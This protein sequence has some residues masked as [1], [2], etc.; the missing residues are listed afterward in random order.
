MKRSLRR[1]N[2][3][4][5]A[6]RNLRSLYFKNW[7]AEWLYGAAQV[8]CSGSY[9][10]THSKI[11]DF[12]KDPHTKLGWYDKTHGTFWV[13]DLADFISDHELQRH[14]LAGRTKDFDYQ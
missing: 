6:A 2:P 5:M 10:N 1:F 13:T 9:L 11:V 14:F 12:Y 7:R 3:A 4:P 8:L